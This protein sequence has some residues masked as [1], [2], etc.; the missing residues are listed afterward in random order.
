MKGLNEPYFIEPNH[1]TFNRIIPAR[2]V[3]APRMV[4]YSPHQFGTVRLKIMGFGSLRNSVWTNQ[5]AEWN[6]FGSMV[7]IASTVDNMNSL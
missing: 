7:H 4:R 3:L 1:S 5:T 6:R 2:T